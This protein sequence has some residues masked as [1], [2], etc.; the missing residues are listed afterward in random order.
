MDI[1][2]DVSDK[3]EEEFHDEANSEELS[4]NTQTERD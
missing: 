2:D 1:V 4:D 3:Y